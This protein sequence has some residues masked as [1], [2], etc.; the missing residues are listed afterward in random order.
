ML[1]KGGVEAGETSRQAAVRE[2]WEEAGIVGAANASPADSI[3]D[4]TP[5]DL[6]VDDHKPH[7]N[8]PAKHQGER[9]FVPRARYTGHEVLLPAKD[10]IRDEWPEAHERQRKKFTLQ[11]AADALEW[12]EDIHRIFVRWAL[13]ISQ[14]A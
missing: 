4:T 13:G 6:T 1:P 5:E 2:L 8:S 3:S 10:A 9:D 11:E 14:E 12:R 7:K